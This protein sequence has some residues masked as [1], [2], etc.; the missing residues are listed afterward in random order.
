MVEIFEKTLCQSQVNILLEYVE[1]RRRQ[2]S[3]VFDESAEVEQ[4]ELLNVNFFLSHSFENFF[5]SDFLEV[6]VVVEEIEVEHN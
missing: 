2:R 3:Q 5:K 1:I 6:R 4:I